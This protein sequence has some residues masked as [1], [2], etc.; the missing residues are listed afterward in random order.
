MVVR[1]SPKAPCGEGRNQY[2]RRLNREIRLLRQMDEETN[3]Q[4]MAAERGRHKVLRQVR[5]MERHLALQAVCVPELVDRLRLRLG[6]EPDEPEAQGASCVQEEEYE[7]IHWEQ[8]QEREVV[9]RVDP[10]E[11]EAKEDLPEQESDEDD[12]EDVHH[13]TADEVQLLYALVMSPKGGDAIKP[14]H[15]QL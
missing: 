10:E 11:Q 6:M 1:Y 2:K 7:N 12:E 15:V 4:H 9:V 3:K 5:S 13:P 14:L 8:Q